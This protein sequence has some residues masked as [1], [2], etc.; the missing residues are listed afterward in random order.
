MHISSETV[1]A[2]PCEHGINTEKSL[3]M[4]RLHYSIVLKMKANLADILKYI[5]KQRSKRFT[6]IFMQHDR[7]ITTQ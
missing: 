6:M 5:P 2:I 7:N 3:Q 1:N 4:L